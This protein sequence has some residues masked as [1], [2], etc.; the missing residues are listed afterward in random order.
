MNAIEKIEARLAQHPGVRWSV[1]PTS[2]EV[3]PADE[4]GF[5]VG[6]R[7]SPAG[8]TVHFDGWHEEFTSEEEAL[9]CFAFGLSPSCRL[10]V[11]LRGST[12]TKWRVESL[13]N[14][15]WTGDSE[16]GLLLQPWWRRARVVYRQNRVLDI[17]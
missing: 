9:N 10:A 4:S 6:L 16:T 2:I 14:G 1:T 5:A 17:D 11:V 15:V 8:L 13:S 12:A 7:L 3:H